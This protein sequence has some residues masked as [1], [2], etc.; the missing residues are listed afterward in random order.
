M[1]V[2]RRSAS[3]WK[4]SAVVANVGTA[5]SSLRGTRQTQCVV[6]LVMTSACLLATCW[7]GVAGIAHTSPGVGHA[8]RPRPDRRTADS[9]PGVRRSRPRPPAPS[10]HAR[11]RG[12]HAAAS[13]RA[14]G[15]WRPPGRGSGDPSPLAHPTDPIAG[16]SSPP[17]RQVSSGRPDS[18]G[19][20]DACCELARKGEGAVLFFATSGRSAWSP[21]RIPRARIP[22]LGFG[23]EKAECLRSGIESPK[24][25]T[26]SVSG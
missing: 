23:R 3:H 10:A 20:C 4:A 22:H 17:R 9:P 25:P 12:G 26:C 5:V 13:Q 19:P 11:G 1:S 2:T 14:S 8:A 6:F 7:C 21:G 16:S 15:G 24:E 18:L